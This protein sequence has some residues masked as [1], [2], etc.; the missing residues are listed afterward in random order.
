MTENCHF[1]DPQCQEQIFNVAVRF[2]WVALFP[3]S[4]SHF[5]V[6]SFVLAVLEVIRR[7]LWNFRGS[8]GLLLSNLFS[9]IHVSLV[10]LENEHIGN[11]DQYRVT[12]E[13][14][15]PYIVR[16]DDK[17]DVYSDNNGGTERRKTFVSF[18][19]L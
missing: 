7:V 6:R 17:D 5:A 3:H 8:C 15:L 13:V 2:S 10:R 4:S 1:F 16:D 11:I 14:P 19:L 18:L 12:R 9:R